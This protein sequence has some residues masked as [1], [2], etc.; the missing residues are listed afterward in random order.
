LAAR[1]IL[2]A[3]AAYLVLLHTLAMGAM[4]AEP[5]GPDASAFVICSDHVGGTNA[6]LPADHGARHSPCALCGLG[7]CAIA[8]APAVG[9]PIRFPTTIAADEIPAAAS[10][11][12][13]PRYLDS[14][15]PR[16]PPPAA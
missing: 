5:L 1:R 16:G 4:A 2:T 8:T 3:I 6:P 9:F 14:S 13:P 15:R 7:H 12:V 11:A 10:I